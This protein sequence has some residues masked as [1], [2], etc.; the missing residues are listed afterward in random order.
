MP[1]AAEEDL[2]RG[3]SAEAVRVYTEDLGEEAARELAE[4][5][6]FR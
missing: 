4:E 2:G 5:V 6:N 1:P 3:L